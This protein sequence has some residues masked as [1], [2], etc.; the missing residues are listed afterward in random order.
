MPSAAPAKDTPLYWVRFQLP[1]LDTFT[2]WGDNYDRGQLLLLNGSATQGRNEQLIRMQ[3]IELT[4]PE[5]RHL[6]AEC[7]VCGAWFVSEYFLNLHGAKQHANR[8]RD[9]IEVAAGMQLGDDAAALR[10]VT[11]D[12]AERRMQQDFPLALEKTK[13]TLEG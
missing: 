5:T 10:D 13:A 8:F 9:D 7:G 11:G 2:Y 12:S 6:H 4:D 3:Y 1:G